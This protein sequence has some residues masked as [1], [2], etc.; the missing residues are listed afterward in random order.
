M[1][2]ISIDHEVLTKSGWKRCINIT[3]EDT[4]YTFEG[5]YISP[6]HIDYIK[7]NT[8]PLIHIKN[9]R[10]NIFGTP[11]VGVYTKDH[12]SIHLN[13]M[14]ETHTPLT[15]KVIRSKDNTCNTHDILYS[16][17]EVEAEA[18][19]LESILSGKHACIEQ[20]VSRVEYHQ[21]YNIFVYN[22]DVI[23]NPQSD[24]TYITY[25]AD[26]KGTSVIRFIMP[27][28]VPICIRRFGAISWIHCC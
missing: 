24:D 1:G 2:Y 6:V 18:I 23:F 17:T 5:K 19:L 28:N 15:L 12:E 8:Q 20:D 3:K 13:D 7:H 27:D 9:R 21:W 26:V 4:L 25:L 22:N 16:K 14:F 11:D 10:I